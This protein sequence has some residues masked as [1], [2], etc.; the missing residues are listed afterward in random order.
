MTQRIC[1][2]PHKVFKLPRKIDL[3]TKKKCFKDREKKKQKEGE[4]EN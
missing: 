2:S 4:R 1:F 3:M